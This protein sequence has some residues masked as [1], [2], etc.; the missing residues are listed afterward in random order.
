VIG[1]DR[2]DSALLQNLREQGIE[3]HLMQD[4]SAVPPECDL[5]VYSEA[6]PAD[7]PERKL[8]DERGIPQQSYFKALGELSAGS[9]VIAVSG[10]HGKS[11]TTAMTARMLI[12]AGKDPTVVVGTKVPDL[13]GKNWRTGTSDIFLLEACEYR[14]SFH[15]LTPSI[16]LLT[17]ADGDHFDA[18]ASI[19]DYQQAF[20]EFLRRLPEDGVV[21]THM[22]DPDCRKIVEA[23]G[24]RAI[25]ADSFPLPTLQTPGL[26]MRQNAQLSLALASVLEIPQEEAIKHLS[27]FAGTWRRMEVKGT[28]SDGVTVVDDYAHHPKEIRASLQAMREAYPS[29]RF[30]VAFQPH[31]HDRTIKLYD[32]FLGAFEVADVVVIPDIYVARNDIEHE[33]VDVP[34]LVSDIAAGSHV[35]AYDGTSME[36]TERLLREKILQKDDVLICMGAG[37]ITKLAD[38]MIRS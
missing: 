24:R 3:I 35:E 28:R 9:R 38:L 26:H 33:L 37:D 36:E 2:S 18:Y 10:T 8:A 25:D 30:V 15:Y 34:K 32:E 7:A 12:L 27:G 29:R 17:N 19:A 11:S 16:V 23:S 21:I 13:E 20:V 4:G 31:T 22:G 14:R 5:F 6:I 1:S